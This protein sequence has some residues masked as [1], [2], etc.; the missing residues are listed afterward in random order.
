[1]ALR[2]DIGIGKLICGERYTKRE[3]I[4]MLSDRTGYAQKDLK[5]IIDDYHELVSDL[6]A[7]GDTLDVG[8]A[9]VGSYLVPKNKFFDPMHKCWQH[10]FVYYNLFSNFTSTIRSGVKR[11]KHDITDDEYLKLREEIDSI[12]TKKRLRRRMYQQK[13]ADIIN[14][15]LKDKRPEVYKEDLLGQKQEKEDKEEVK[16]E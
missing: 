12:D 5:S 3:I 16:D 8:Y 9:I 7:N 1:M 4:R 2:R 10:P 15:L 11:F 13:R 6:L 14:N